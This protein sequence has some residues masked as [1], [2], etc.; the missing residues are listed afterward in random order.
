MEQ[1]AAEG[2]AFDLTTYAVATG[3]LGRTLKLLGLKRAPRDETPSL[4][5][6]I[7]AQRQANRAFA[8]TG[9]EEG[10][11]AGTLEGWNRN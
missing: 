9:E 3:H 8:I 5:E 6:Y 11:T 4:R 7:D 1:K 2:G 10:E